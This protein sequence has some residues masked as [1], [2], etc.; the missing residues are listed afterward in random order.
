MTLLYDRKCAETPKERRILNKLIWRYRRKRKRKLLKEAIDAANSGAKRPETQKSTVV[1]WRR[2]CGPT[3]PKSK[4]EER[5][6]E[7]YALT[8]EEQVR[9][10]DEKQFWIQRWFDACDDPENANA[11]GLHPVE[12]G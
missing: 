6:T 12:Y 11:E 3:S 9:E 4:L 10:N 1:N 5:F 8:P 2:I 7:L